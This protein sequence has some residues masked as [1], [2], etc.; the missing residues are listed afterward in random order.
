MTL[1]D[2]LT[3][4]LNPDVVT[5]IADYID[6]PV[7]KTRKA[8]NGLVY[9]ITGGLMKRTTT[10]IGVN[11]LFNHIQKGRY[12]GSLLDNLTT[13]LRE[14]AQTNTLITQG[15]DVISH[16]LPAM[17]SSIGS[18][19]STYAGIRNSSAISLLGLTTTIV[20]HMLGRRVKDQK[21]DADTLASSLFAERDALVNAVPEEF[22]PRLVE[23]V[24]L[25]QVM[26]GVA[27]PARRSV[28]ESAANSSRSYSEPVRQP[29][30]YES[31]D[32]S[33]NDAG[34]LAKWG[35]GGLLVVALMAV[36]YYVYQ[37]TQK[38][39]NDNEPTTDVSPVTSNTVQSDT[40][41]RSLAVPADSAARTAP[42]SASAVVTPATPTATASS[43]GGSLTQQLTPYVSNPALP[44]GRIFPLT[45]VAF[46][47]GSLSLTAGSQAT[48][49]ELA[50]LLKAN[51]ALQIQ[52]IGYANDASGALTNKSLSFKRVNQIKQQLMASG[53][54]FVRIDAIGRG[55]G[56]SKR[57]TS[58]VAKPTLR[59]IDMKVVAK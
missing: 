24:G 2:S 56:V 22:M 17:K 45:G 41:A 58:G 53:I 47:P 52:L 4:V 1:F 10:E 38:H 36:G 44:K 43:A 42:K 27:A 13:V 19:I 23:K 18:M 32:D 33:D 39:N 50:T 25:Q 35:I 28:V 12:D 21:L 3:D 40:V 48:I 8:V 30:S 7:D 59:K 6:E 16:L 34:S 29:I 20:L 55:S 11:Q 15:N 26:A 14:P 46:Q 31:A 49:N 5:R 37:N 57:D 9:T 54:D 51:P